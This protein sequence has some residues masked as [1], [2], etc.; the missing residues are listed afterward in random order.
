MGSCEVPDD[1]E[2]Q[3]MGLQ[4]HDILVTASGWGRGMSFS[5]IHNL[6]KYAS[7]V[8]QVGGCFYVQIFRILIFLFNFLVLHSY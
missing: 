2:L 1:D 8:L 4:P 7:R 6:G 3:S 5:F